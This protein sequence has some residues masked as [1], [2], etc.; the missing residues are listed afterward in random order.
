MVKVYQHETPKDVFDES[1]EAWCD[2]LTS[3]EESTAD[4]AWTNAVKL[5]KSVDS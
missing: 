2:S 1:F 4:P 5:L 3:G